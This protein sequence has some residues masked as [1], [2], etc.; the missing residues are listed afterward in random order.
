MLI[1]QDYMELYD[2]PVVI[3]QAIGIRRRTSPK[4]RM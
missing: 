1:N 3:Q 2:I 4:Y